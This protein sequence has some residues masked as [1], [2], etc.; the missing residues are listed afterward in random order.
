LLLDF[1]GA[2]ARPEPIFEIVQAG[3]Q[4]AHMIRGRLSH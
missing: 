2:A 4:R 3:D 1:L